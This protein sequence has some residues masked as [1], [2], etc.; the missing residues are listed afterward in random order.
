MISKNI[1]VKPC[2]LVALFLLLGQSQ[3]VL[4]QQAP[5]PSQPVDTT[6]T[7]STPTSPTSTTSGTTAA[8]SAGTDSVDQGGGSGVVPSGG[9]DTAGALN[10]QADLFTGR[11]TYKI[12]IKVAPGR[13][14]AEPKLGLGYNSSS[15]NG[16]CGIGWT[17]ETGYIQRDLRKGVPIQ[18]PAGS[19]DPSAKYDDSKGFIASI[20]GAG[21]TLVRVGSTNLNPIVYRQQVDTAF[22]TYNYY[23]NNHWEVVDKSGNIFIFG[24][25]LTNQMENSK[26]GWV[27]NSG[28]STFRWALDKVIDVNGNETFLKYTTDGGTL[29]LTNISYN[30][31]SNSP[32]LAATHEVNFILTNRPDT[33]ITFMSGYRVKTQKLLSAIE[34]KAGGLN[35]RKYVLGY[36]QSS[37]TLRSLLASVTEYGS[38]FSSALPTIFFKYQVQ[39]PS[40][41]P[42]NVWPGMTIQGRTNNLDGWGSVRAQSSTD[43]NLYVTTADLDGDGLMDRVM[44]K[45]YSPYPKYL[46]PNLNTGTNFSLTS[47]NYRWG[48]L[49]VQGNNNSVMNS[50]AAA[51][52]SGYTFLDVVDINGDGYPDRVMENKG[53]PYTNLFV[54]LNSGV[55]GSNGFVSSINWGPV[56]SEAGGEQYGCVR[57]LYTLDLI[58]I[59]GDGLPDRVMRELNSPFNLFKVQLNTGFGFTA[60]LNWTNVDGQG[61]SAA[62]WNTIAHQ[63][64]SGN[65]NWE[66]VLQDINGDGLPDRVMRQINSPYT[67]FVVQLNN[68]AGFEPDEN[69]GA[70]DNQGQGN[71]DKTWNSPIGGT[72]GGEVDA[73]LVDINGD[74]LPDRVMKNVSSFNRWRVQLNTGSGFGTSFDWT[75]MDYQNNTHWQAVSYQ[76]DSHTYVDFFDINGDGLPDRV[77][78]QTNR[79]L[80]QLNKGPFPDLM[81]VISNGLGGSLQV[82]Y[83]ASTTLDNR[84]T[85]WASDRWLERTKNLM[86]FNVWVVNKVFVFD[87]MG[88]SSTNTYAFKGGYYNSAEKEFRGFSQATV[89]DPYWAKTTTYFHQSGGR[90]NTAL[91][92]YLDQGSESKKGIPF[93][94]EVIGSDG[95]TNKISLNKVEEV[96]LNSN[97]WYFP[98]ISQSIVLTYEGLSSYRAVARQ[99]SYDTNTENLVM[100]AKLGEVTNIVFQGQTFTDIG[101][102]SVYTWVTYTNIGNIFDKPSAVRNTSDGAGTSRLRETQMSYDSH[103][104]MTSSQVWLDSTGT[105]VTAGSNDYDQY[106]NLTQS[107][108][109]AGIAT[110]TA[111]DSTYQQ[112]PVTQ[113]TGTFTNSSISDVRSG[114]MLT[115]TDVKGLVVSNTYDVFFRP[116]ASYIST[117]AYG[118]PSLW[119]SKISYSLGGITGGI[120]YN[121]I[122]KQINDAVDT[123]NGFETYTYLDGIGRTI[124][125]REEA[126]T[127]QFRVAN[128]CYDRRGNPYFQT[129]PYF[130]SGT[131]F[132]A[133]SG[134]YLGALTEYDCIGRA[135]RVT[136]AVQG[137]FTSGSL[138]ST[139]S[140]GGD[141]GSPVGPATTAFVD[142][143]N[144]WATVVTDSEGKSKKSYRDAYGRTITI[145]EVTTSGNFNTSY[146]YDLIGNPTNVTD[147]ANNSTRMSYDSLGR[148]T[149]MTDPDM[150]TWTY[151]YDSAGR[152][153][154]QIDAR[155]N[156][157]TFTYSDQLGRLTSKQIY[158]SGNALVGTITYTYDTSDDINY[159]VFKGQLYKVT[160]L[161]GYERSSYD[162]RGRVLKSARYLNLNSMEYATQAIY[163]DADRVQQLI[164]PGN[165]ATIKNTYDT[166]GNLIQ[167]KSLAGTG[168]QEIFYSPQGGFNELG[169]LLSYTNGNGVLTT[170]IYFANSKRLQRVQ[171]KGTNTLQDLSYT[172]DTVSDLKSI[173]DGVYSN[174]A[175]ASISSIVYDD[176]YRVKSLNS[177]ARGIK[178]YGYNSIGNILTNQDCGSGP[179]SYGAKPHAVTSANGVT[180]AYDAC[181]NMT[182][183]GSQTLAYDEQNQ[184]AFVSATNTLVTF[185]YDDSGERLWRKGTNSYSIWIGGIYEINNG[186]VLCH[187]MADGKL[188]ATF[189]P[190]CGGLWSQVVGEKNWYLASTTIQSVLNWPFQKG[191]G[192]ITMFAG[193][194]AAILSVC[195][196]AGRRIRL[197]SHEIKRT[198][199]LQSLWRHAVT[200]VSI[201]A[202]LWVSTGNV[203]AATYSPVFYYYHS[204]NLG[205]SSILTDRSGSLVQH[206]EYATFGNTSYSANSS[207]FPISN[208]YTG[209]IADDETGLYYYGA[210]YYDPQLGRFIQPD[211]IV[212]SPDDPQTLNRYSYC[213]NNPLN[214]TDPT[215]N[216][217]DIATM[218]FITIAG[219]AVGAQVAGMTGGNVMLGALGGAVGGLLSG[220]GIG[221]LG[222]ELQSALG[223]CAQAAGG[224]IGG[225]AG[226]AASAAI[227]GGNMGMG[228]LIGGA[229][230]ALFGA[231]DGPPP[232]GNP[233]PDG[234]VW[235][236]YKSGGWYTYPDLH[237]ELYSNTGAIAAGRA[238]G[239]VLTAGQAS[240][241]GGAATAAST[242]VANGSIGAP[243]FAVSCIPFV[244]SAWESASAFSSGHWIMGTTYAAMAVWDLT[245]I[246]ATGKLLLLGG[247]KVAAA[248]SVVVTG[249]RV[250]VKGAIYKTTKEAT[251]AAEKLGYTRIKDLSHG[252]AVFSNGKT[253]ITRDV[254]GHAAGGAW[255][256]ANSAKALGAKATRSGTYDINLKKIGD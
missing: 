32:A 11:F 184:L 212:Q 81:N 117:D 176:L 36:T 25:G 116:V 139:S 228:A 170:N 249:V 173:D 240:A 120:S 5:V 224:S 52:G 3:S 31:N 17:L 232:N 183:R 73:T 244:G 18:W 76:S 77:M 8:L 208:R 161:Q 200:F 4:A 167:V 182:T 253:F 154:Q 59:N 202:F 14:G 180:Y 97:G 181:G 100:T 137:S 217:F 160:D 243:S 56:T 98:F 203:E 84:N 245:G 237:T 155:T 54:Q 157:L 242:S 12:P 199:R 231:L 136:P 152:M 85:N 187:V 236:D 47:T 148:K 254:D 205:S 16:W 15:G 129:L 103:G 171:V 107:T 101:S 24:E 256:M 88:N 2:L 27:A 40:F 197:K 96:M 43:G 226:G 94:I 216:F 46:V 64:A 71:T 219:A 222:P 130:S 30:A 92:E 150:G 140:T 57:T 246:G 192:Q 119:Q 74:G 90:D 165:A 179:Y 61:N 178:N 172:Y 234:G 238:G 68:G 39:S 153:T 65:G 28:S 20:G 241:A 93:R 23:T 239:D 131:G 83:A 127:S 82:S 223:C 214:F 69:W 75:G 196:V 250:S 63:D 45:D 233:S 126:E 67:A 106:G 204:D 7:V 102:D 210:R 60:L 109:A 248:T 58:D 114:T 166:A 95:A 201:S 190:Q 50:P 26:S 108:D 138:V 188:V 38:D 91:G 53:G 251:V 255:K 193:T 10:F 123:A 235:T 145:T 115:G 151:S 66:A 21:S 118:A 146:T 104:R 162:V 13:Q 79:F 86:P 70:V 112:F 144:P 198:L 1:Q 99:F 62:E 133:I 247:L 225:A 134:N 229:A 125:T 44:L 168:T 110:T 194:W 135:Y 189:E 89:T 113:I 211:T 164:Y 121:Y 175:S 143:S 37:S 33:N 22:L 185:G 128:A 206:Y 149:S 186:K 230:G 55:Q 35:V 215:G 9:G 78:S 87:G 158:N 72:H 177:T 6:S 51:N 156:K 227:Q 34:V 29:Y 49:D 220:I 191:R 41:A 132:T 218:A 80:V 195:I 111:Y 252:Q 174:S 213:G 147:S 221:Y 159:T 209:Q 142:G 105:F 42:T 48:M 163:D 122:H 124:Q 141:T 169:Q 19:S 207:A